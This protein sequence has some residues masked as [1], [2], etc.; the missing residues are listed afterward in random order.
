M[1]EH[2]Q[3]GRARPEARLVGLERAHEAPQRECAEGQ[4]ERVHAREVAVVER[5]GRER[6]D[7]GGRGADRRADSARPSSPTAT[8]ASSRPER[9][10]RRASR[11]PAAERCD[12]LG[13]QEVQ[14]RAAAHELHRLEQLAQRTARDHDRQR[15][16]AVHDAVAEVRAAGERPPRRRQA[17]ML[18]R[19]AS[20]GVGRTPQG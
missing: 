20:A 2:E 5:D 1:V 6:D 17:A 15:L 14:R 12:Q 7:P 8:I 9:R 19:K 16:V 10:D 18:A 13:E 4:E 3:R 11:Q